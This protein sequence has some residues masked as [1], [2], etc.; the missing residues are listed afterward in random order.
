MTTLRATLN[1]LA[2]EFAQSVI[3]AIRT[4]SLDDLLEEAGGAGRRRG[5]AGTSSVQ[6]GGASNGNKKSGRLG[7]RSADQIA[8]VVD[9]I[10]SLLER[11]PDGLRAEDIRTELGLVRKEL[12]RPLAEALA[13][14]RIG[15][16]G[17]KRATTYFAK[18]GNVT[19][20]RANGVAVS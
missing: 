3:Q 14:K 15:K 1:Q 10:V 17:Q 8:G 16:Q 11:H 19:K 13:S 5:G 2:M 7:R 20:K 12:P 18:N 6:R 4:A 9:R